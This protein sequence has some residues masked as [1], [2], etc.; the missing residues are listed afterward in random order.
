MLYAM[1]MIIAIKHKPVVVVTSIQC[2]DLGD[3]AG[4]WIDEALD[5]SGLRLLRAAPNAKRYIKDYP[6]WFGS[7]PSPSDHIMVRPTANPH[8]LMDC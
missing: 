7:S 8:I 1:R 4:A 6:L 3:E 5:K 2:I